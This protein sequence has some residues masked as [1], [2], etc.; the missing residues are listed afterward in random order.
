MANETELI[1]FKETW[2]DEYLK[3]ICGF[4]NARGGIL[5]IGIND[6]GEAV[7]VTNPQKLME[8]LPNK[9]SSTLGI[10]PMVNCQIKQGKDIISITV[11]GSNA[12][13]AYHGKYYVRSGTTLQELS[14]IA[15][16]DFIMKRIGM[17]WESQSIPN[18]TIDDISSEAINYFIRAG[19]KA[20]RIPQNANYS[21]IETVLKNRHLLDSHGRLTLAALLI[22]GKDP[23]QFCLTSGVKIG[24]FGHSYSDLIRQD[25]VNGNLIQMA[26]N[27]ISLLDAKYLIRPIHYEGLQRIEPLEIPYEALREILFN[28]IIHKDYRGAEITIRIFQD[29][30]EIWNPG[31]LPEDFDINNLWSKHGSIKRNQLIAETFYYAGFIENWGRGF[32]IIHNAFI[33]EKLKL[34]TF[35]AHTGGFE[36]SIPREKYLS[37]VQSNKEQN[38]VTINVTLN[39]TLELSKRQRD[40]LHCL[41]PSN[42]FD[43]TL[44]VTINASELSRK[45]NVT[46]RTIMRDLNTLISKGLIRRSGSKKKGQWEIV[47]RNL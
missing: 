38:N 39:N 31:R 29:R 7:G 1:E 19:V 3:W 23:Q 16:Q 12:P 44:N 30:M 40:I 32:E 14:G 22:F 10:I 5:Y 28:A 18:A 42:D 34:P 45:Y 26:D 13:V 43:V 15:L 4:A 27:V 33:K 8:D 20:K 47:K 46:R 24:L 37:S 36:V 9:I 25:I 11:Y 2:R 21:S 35:D 6:K 41:T 17:T